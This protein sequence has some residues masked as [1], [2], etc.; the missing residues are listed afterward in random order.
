L[1]KFKLWSPQKKP[2]ISQGLKNGAGGES[3]SPDLMLAKHRGKK[4]LA[5]ASSAMLRRILESKMVYP[6]AGRELEKM[7]KESE[8]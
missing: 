2:L 4:R 5:D 3:R 6:E 8:S 1:E 7:E